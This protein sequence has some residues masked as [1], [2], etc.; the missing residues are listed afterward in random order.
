MNKNFSIALLLILFSCGKNKNL[1]NT[2]QTD[3]TFLQEEVWNNFDDDADG[4]SNGDELK[5][6]THPELINPPNLRSFEL[7]N[8]TF[9]LK[10]SDVQ[11]NQKPLRFVIDDRP[12][13]RYLFSVMSPL[14]KKGHNPF[15]NYQFKSE[16]VS[17]QTSSAFYPPSTLLLRPKLDSNY[18]SLMKENFYNQKISSNTFL[19][20][21]HIQANITLNF[22]TN[23]TK[24]NGLK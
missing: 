15:Q 12:I 6:G 1:P 21:D 3:K 8:V 9:F 18:L 16:H 23:L 7:S 13:N 2:I 17:I 4:I 5:Q 11:I 19:E 22:P 10:G 24:K 20:E 14:L